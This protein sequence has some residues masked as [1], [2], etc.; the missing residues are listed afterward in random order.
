MPSNAI[1]NS[2]TALH[3]SGVRTPARTTSAPWP[4]AAE[5]TS[6][7]GTFATAPATDRPSYWAA[8]DT[9]YAGMP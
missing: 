5:Y 8:T 9:A 7:A 3:R 1:D 4:R 6:P 2:S